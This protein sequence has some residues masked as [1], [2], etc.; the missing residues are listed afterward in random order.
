MEQ[1]SN[2]IFAFYFWFF[3]EDRRNKIYNKEQ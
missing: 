1:K 3:I 2:D